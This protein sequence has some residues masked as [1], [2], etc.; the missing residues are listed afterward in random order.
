M[1]KATFRESDHTYW[2][3][4][5]KIPISVTQLLKKHGLSPSYAGV[6]AEML[7]AKAERGNLIHKEVEDFINNGEMGFTPE[8]Y[9][10]LKIVEELQLLEMQSEVIVNSDKL[11]GKADIMA[12][13]IVD[14]KKIKVLADVKTTA[15]AHK[16]SV[17]WQ[18]SL[19]E[20]LDGVDYDEFYLILLGE[21]SKPIALERITKQEVERLLECENKG[22]PYTACTLADEL[23]KELQ[24]VES[25]YQ[26][27][28]NKRENLTERLLAE[29]EKQKVITAETDL[30]RVTY[31][32]TSSKSSFDQKAFAK[33]EPEMVAKFTKQVPVKA[34]V[35]ITLKEG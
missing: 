3:E 5:K 9:D 15:V 6:S 23:M 22:E 16:E 25:E 26:T 33:A 8:F 20:H 4:K 30:V 12:R 29:M 19:L 7:N 18:L 24:E 21:N 14:G 1:A 17:R 35:R 2:L 34:S 13:R 28:K 10:F 31:T 11:A 32:P 27:A